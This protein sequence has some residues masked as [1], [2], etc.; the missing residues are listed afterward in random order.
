MTGILSGI[1][2]GLK[3]VW[4]SPLLLALLAYGFVSNHLANPFGFLLPVVVVDVYHQEAEAYGLLISLMGLG[5]LIG[6]LVVASLGGKKRG[7]LLIMGSCTAGAALLLVASVP[8]YIVG[9]GVLV[10]FGLGNAVHLTQSQ[11][12]VLE[13]VEDRFRGR[14]TSIF[15]MN[16]GLLPFT[17]ILVAFAF[18]S[19]G[20]RFTIGILAMGLLVAS[21]IVLS[22]QRKIRE[23]D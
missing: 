16:A 22:T 5:A 17:V 13:H 11:T 10:V 20:S 4:R 23:L 15:T 3:N 9:A 12:L 18:D 8:L 7:L 1:G 21:L 6:A 19:L 14:T 2:E